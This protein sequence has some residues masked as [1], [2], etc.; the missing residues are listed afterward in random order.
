MW[1]DGQRG[2]TSLHIKERYREDKWIDAIV[3]GEV[4]LD[5]MKA[6]II[7]EPTIGSNFLTSRW[8]EEYMWYYRKVFA[9]S[10]EALNSTAWL[11]FEGLDYNAIIYLNGKEIAKH[12]NFFYPCRINV[13]EYLLE[14]ENIVVVKLESGLYG[15]SEKT[16]QYNTINGDTE[17]HLLGK[18]IWVRK[19]A[20]SYSWDWSPRYLNVGIYKPVY[21]EFANRV[22]VENFVV[23]SEVNETLNEGSFK[24][25]MFVE[26]LEETVDGVYTVEIGNIEKLF[27]CNVSVKNGMQM[28]EIE[29]IVENPKLWWP[30]NQGEQNLYNFKACLYVDGKLISEKTQRIGFR[31]IIVNQ[32]SHPECGNYFIIE[33]NNRKIFAKGSNLVPSDIIYARIDSKRYET[34]VDRAMEANFNLLRVWGGG[35]YESDEFYEL[36]DQKGIMVWQEFIFACATYPMFDKEWIDNVKKEVIYNIRRLASHASLVIWCGNNEVE[37]RYPNRSDNVITDH[38]LYHRTLPIIL[39]QED[40]TRFYHP[41]SPY[42]SHT[43]DPNSDYIGDQHPWSVGF[44]NSNFYDYRKMICRF[45]NEGGIMG[46]TSIETMKACFDENQEYLHS[47]SGQLHD[48]FFESFGEEFSPDNVVKYWMDINP[49]KLSIEEYIFAGG[50]LQGEG[51]REYIDNFRRRMYDSAAAIFW[52]F[53]DIWPATRSWTIVDYYLNRTPSYYHV[54]RA[55]SPVSVVITN[56]NGKVCVYGINEIQDEFIGELE[57]GIVTLS[58][59]Y[60]FDYR[61]NVSI[62]G[63]TSLCI[64]EFDELKWTEIGFENSCAFAKLTKEN[65]IIAS[66]RLFMKRIFEM[67]WL[68]ADIDIKRDGEF[69]VF[70]SKVFVWAVCIDLNGK[71]ALYDNMFD[72]LPNQPY[73]IPWHCNEPL[74]KIIFNGNDFLLD[75]MSKGLK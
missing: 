59:D 56:E 50:V 13:S 24:A 17:D 48:N 18:R 32:S 60:I 45:S 39:K 26:G 9:L 23:L 37:M 57:Y 1:S 52:M 34:L 71:E 10:K 8:V 14:G 75:K 6:G 15:V 42:S 16:I 70:E 4:H 68:I 41:S 62:R 36:C 33:I 30:I 58:G 54:K 65:K 40:P 7:N 11:V 47:F 46:P 61:L 27:T 44:S 12:S 19:P 28:L 31:R 38:A 3:P 74:P 20:N 55:F 5:L 43:E 35:I 2:G 29:G 21:L 51:L 73:R 64:A 72:L 53:N 67:N 25:R 69:V 22:R 49:T 66:N 63:N